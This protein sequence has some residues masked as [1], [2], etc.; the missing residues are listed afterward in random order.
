MIP[1]FVLLIGLAAGFIGSIG[2]GGSFISIP[3]LLLLGVSP[4]V[5]IGTN[6]FGALG[7]NAGGF[8][9]YRK[10][11]AW[12][13]IPLLG[14]CAIGGA[15]LGTHFLL[16]LPTA[17]LK[18]AVGALI[19]LAIP[20]LLQQKSWGVQRQKTS[21]VR[22]LL[23]TL[24]YLPAMAYGAFLG[25]GVGTVSRYLL[26]EGF[27]LDVIEANATDMVT[28]LLMSTIAVILYARSK[29]IDY[30][31]GFLLLAGM[32]LGSLLGSKLAIQKGAAWAK[33][34]Y[35]VIGIAVGIW[36]LL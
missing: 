18:K 30:G 19:L 4:Q 33:V 2:G 5:T 21:F 26:M 14:A 31:L 8:W 27:G 6:R 15:F 35:A 25:A 11:V 28:G 29:V 3:G 23:A 1:F 22:K 24:F 7:L 36:L 17:T 32:L 34:F 13:L 12:K 9:G 16:S 20:F 10:S